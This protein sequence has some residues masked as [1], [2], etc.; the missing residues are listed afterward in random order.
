MDLDTVRLDGSQ[1]GLDW[2]V[3]V[4]LDLW[5]FGSGRFGFRWI[6]SFGFFGSGLSVF[7]WIGLFGFFSDLD[8]CF[9]LD[10]IS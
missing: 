4:G 5:F 6:G 1:D 9:S 10:W 3:F 2:S 7:R 8:L